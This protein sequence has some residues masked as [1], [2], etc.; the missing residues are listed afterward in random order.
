MKSNIGF[1]SFSSH[2]KNKVIPSIQKNKKIV[3]IKIFTL[4]K[5]DKKN[6]YL[7]NLKIVSDKKNFLRDKK[8]DV[9]YISSISKNHFKNCMDS[10]KFNKNVICEKPICENSNDFKKLLSKAKKKNL[11][12]SE[13]YQY[14]YHPLFLKLKKLINKKEIG[15]INFVDSSFTIPLNDRKNFN[16]KVLKTLILRGLILKG[17]S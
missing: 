11:K 16:R 6:H 8:L 2:L 12:I 10:L 4:K 7:K 9:I 14:I 3:P 13:V 15:N 5:I 17:M 1:W